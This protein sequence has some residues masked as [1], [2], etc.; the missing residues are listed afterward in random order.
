MRKKG[1]LISRISMKARLLGNLKNVESLIN[2]YPCN[3]KI[4]G[5]SSLKYLIREDEKASERFYIVDLGKSF[6]NFSTFSSTSPLNCIEESLARLLTIISTLGDNYEV[7]V[8]NLFP[9][10]IYALMRQH[11]MY[12]MENLKEPNDNSV[13][14]MLARRIKCL[15]IENNKLKSELS[16]ANGKLMRILT[17][18]IIAKYPNNASLLEIAENNGL[19]KNDVNEALSKLRKNGYF[20]RQTLGG[21]FSVVKL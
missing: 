6:I 17:N 3:E 21:R 2:Q 11:L 18:L 13:D 4:S 19:S 7:E 20:V 8:K 10:L 16:E 5:G 15:L 14:L 12:Y 1:Y 9:Y